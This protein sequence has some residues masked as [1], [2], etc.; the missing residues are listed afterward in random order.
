MA[1]NA[2]LGVQF[3]G[4]AFAGGRTWVAEG[5]ATDACLTLASCRQVADLPAGSV[6]RDPSMVALRKYL[7]KQRGAVCGL[8]FPFGLPRGV[9]KDQP[10]LEFVRSFDKRF[11]D[12]AD[13]TEQCRKAGGD[14]EHWRVTDRE[15]GRRSG[16][17]KRRL[18]YQ[19]F[20]G[21]RDILQ[22]LVIEGL[23]VAV[24]MQEPAKGK[25]LLL[26]SAP[27]ST[28]RRARIAPPFKGA[29]PLAFRARN[30]VLEA[31]ERLGRLTKVEEPLRERVLQDPEGDSLAS[32][33][34]AVTAAYASAHRERW[35]DDP[36][37]GYHIEGRIFGE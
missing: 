11:K 31:Y 3:S 8:V 30:G 13:F 33:V 16:P 34:A 10:W 25:T 4:A 20:H 24:P 37:G 32:V 6:E 28:L 19:T 17:H 36:T 26:E 14:R 9:V 29:A 23:A 15:W 35:D 12:V 7:A 22:P 2:I 18:A 21:I 5:T 27:A 1:H